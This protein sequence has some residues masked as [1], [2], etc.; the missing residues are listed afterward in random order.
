M[1]LALNLTSNMIWT[2]NFTSL[3]LN[4]LLYE[5]VIIIRSFQGVIRF[6]PNI[7]NFPNIM[8]ITLYAP[9]K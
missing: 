9:N 4:F 5:M 8:S 1:D 6:K 2:N 7:G 3:G